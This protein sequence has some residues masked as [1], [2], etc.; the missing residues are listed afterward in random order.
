MGYSLISIHQFTN[1]SPIFCGFPPMAASMGDMVGAGTGGTMGGGLAGAA[2]TG[3]RCSTW[4]FYWETHR[5]S[6]ENMG[7]T[8]GKSWENH[9][10]NHRKSLEYMGKTH[11][12]SSENMG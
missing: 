4:R 2:S 1:S 8:M 5:K 12:K 11:G 9:G 7:K 10:K 6:L 3:K